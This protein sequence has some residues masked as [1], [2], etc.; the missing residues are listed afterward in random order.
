[1]AVAADGEA[2][3]LVSVVRLGTPKPVYNLTVGGTH[4]YFVRAGEDDLWGRNADDCDLSTLGRREHI[5]DGDPVGNGGGHR[6][7]TGKPGKSEF[8]PNWSDDEVMH[9]IS[10]V[11]TDPSSH[12]FPQGDREV[13]EGTRG[14]IDIRVILGGPGEDPI[15][16]GFPT[17]IGRNP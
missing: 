6:G 5:L 3:T 9:E 4:T 13:A 11:A 2:A 17:N 14:L 10:D 12:R 15:I 16:T 8:P 1:M 7:G